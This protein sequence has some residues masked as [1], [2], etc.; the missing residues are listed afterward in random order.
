MGGAASISV[1][2]AEPGKITH[3]G[4]LQRIVFGEFDGTDSEPLRHIPS[5]LAGAGIDTVASSAITGLLRE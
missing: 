1:F 4:A 3:H 2:I 5:T